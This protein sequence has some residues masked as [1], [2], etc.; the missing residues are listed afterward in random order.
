MKPLVQLVDDR[1]ESLDL[2]ENILAR[3][4]D[5]V[6]S[7]DGR[8]A[9]AWLFS[10]KRLPDLILLDMLMPGLDGYAVL[11]LLKSHPALRDIPVICVT[12]DD[13]EQSALSSGAAD[14]IAKP[15]SP[16]IVRLRVRNQILLKQQVEML[17]ELVEEKIQQ[18]EA[19]RDNT[20]HVLADIIEC[21]HHESGGHVKRVMQYVQ[22]IVE[23]LLKQSRY[24]DE[25]E[26]LRPN[27]LV[28]SVL[29][30][31][32][33]K[34]GIPDDILCKPGKLTKEEFTVMQR[35]TSLGKTIIE[36]IFA[37]GQTDYEYLHHCTDIAYYH[38]EWFDGS[39]YPTGRCG[40]KIPLSARIMAVAD[41]YDALVTPRVYKQAL[42]HNEALQ[43]MRQEGGT[44][45][46][47]V[48]LE[49]MLSNAGQFQKIA[50]Y[51]GREN[52]A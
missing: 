18:A 5:I 14:Y 40:T 21:R 8:K 23:Q 2:L 25:L 19:V 12:V 3:E 30:H 28:K 46:D 16:G 6:R 51:H 15:Y 22:V 38:H 52:P 49:A 7:E 4:Y 35:H 47:P 45:F 29:L 13:L 9:L 39:G 24:A 36:S 37:P 10:A 33:G 34:I 20:L 27:V 50:Q 32:V 42:Q 41:V 17:K 43:I 26:R 1:P 44:H 11:R 48:V 31:D